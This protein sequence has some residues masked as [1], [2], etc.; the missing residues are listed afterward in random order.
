MTSH[1]V[2]VEDGDDENVNY[3]NF[4]DSIFNFL[5]VKDK[6]KVRLTYSLV[7]RK[8]KKYL[9]AKLHILIRFVIK[10]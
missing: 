10:H 1:F 2:D 6:S 4:M 9:L 3:E 8:Y 5:R 7:R